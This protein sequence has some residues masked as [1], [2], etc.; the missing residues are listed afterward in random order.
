M[1][2]TTAKALISTRADIATLTGIWQDKPITTEHLMSIIAYCDMDSYSTRFS[3]TFRKIKPEETFQSVKQ[4]NAEYWWQSKLL[5]ELV[6]CY[7]SQ[8][9]IDTANLQSRFGK[10][11]GFMKSKI[12]RLND[13]AESGPFCMYSLR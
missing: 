12:Q 4:R 8:G 13:N 7:G 10:M 6:M 5:K 11:S 2:T 1:H 9:V 3:A